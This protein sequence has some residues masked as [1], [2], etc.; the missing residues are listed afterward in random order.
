MRKFGYV[1]IKVS[2]E[3]S[4]KAMDVILTNS[5][6]YKKARICDNENLEITIFAK[7]EEKF[8]YLF[9]SNSIEAIYSD[10]VGFFA[11][12][13]RYFKRYGFII[14]A[15]FLLLCVYLSSLFVWRIDIEGNST[16][17]DEEILDILEECG[18]SL[19][20]FIPKIN[21][22]DVHNEFL[23]KSENIAWISINISGN[24]AK[25]LVR[26]NLKQNDEKKSTYTN[27]ISKYDAQI[28]L[29]KLYNGEK[30]VINGD[31]VKKGDLLISGIMNSQSQGVRYVHADG[32]VMGYVN[33]PINVKIPFKNEQKVYTDK[34]YT[35][36]SYK[37][38]SKLINFSLKYRNYGELYDKIEEK[39][40]V[41]LFGKIQLPI[42]VYTTTYKE[43]EIV[44]VEYSY[45]QAVDIAF[46][47]LRAQMDV[48]LENAELISKNLET[49]WDDEYLYIT[50]NLYCL[51]NIA[52]LS[53]FEVNLK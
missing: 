35:E 48:A 24:V 49:S 50:C 31:I 15:L 14:G 42:E 32:I 22:A 11:K 53:E 10:N 1:I 23:L 30:V 46:A 40:K 19:G 41:T 7:H 21:Y 18:I 8:K 20:T 34:E 6:V 4:G 36:K 39:E 43:Y 38:F 44:S 28:H 12:L 33:K 26:E 17:D 37:I 13:S 51:E 3:C 29:V 9:E 27:V 2:K 16:I 25:V 47:E 52:E 5:L 45:S